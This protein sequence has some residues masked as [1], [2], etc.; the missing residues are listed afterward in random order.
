[1]AQSHSEL[2]FKQLKQRLASEEGAQLDTKHVIGATPWFSISPSTMS[3]QQAPWW[4]TTAA[5]MP[6]GTGNPH[7]QPHHGT[8]SGQAPRGQLRGGHHG[9]TAVREPYDT[10]EVILRASE[11][12]QA[13]ASVRATPGTASGF[14]QPPNIPQTPRHATNGSPTL[15][16]IAEHGGSNDDEE[17]DDEEEEG[18]ESENDKEETGTEEEQHGRVRVSRRKAAGSRAASS[19]RKGA[20]ASGDGKQTQR[21]ALHKPSG[22]NSNKAKS[23]TALA[24][25]E[26]QKSKKRAPMKKKKKLPRKKK[27]VEKDGGKGQPHVPTV[28][29]TPYA[30]RRTQYSYQDADLTASDVHAF[31]DLQWM[32][33]LENTVRQQRKRGSPLR[34]KLRPSAVGD[35]NQRMAATMPSRHAVADI[36]QAQE[37]LWDTFTAKQLQRQWAQADA[38]EA[39]DHRRSTTNLH[40][41]KRPQSAM[42]RSQTAQALHQRPTSAHT[43]AGT[44][45]LPGSATPYNAA[46]WAGAPAQLLR[47][48]KRLSHADERA[49]VS[50]CF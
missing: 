13:H 31:K 27:R 38:A 47:K 48:T 16:G 32:E 12:L 9:G 24:D 22:P 5:S 34:G 41:R 40:S 23:S 46:V 8:L 44:A 6:S 49:K 50:C 7:D 4:S 45:A 29:A 21:R 15:A 33:E 17:E 10:D 3:K 37:D 25:K 42:P 19:S 30:A 28:E 35:H 43:R 26:T 11:F 20:R 14:E 36:E 39:A 1:M 18:D 2:R